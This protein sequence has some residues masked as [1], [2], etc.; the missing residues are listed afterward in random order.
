M[1]TTQKTVVLDCETDAL[2]FTKCHVVVCRDVETDEVATFRHIH[3]YP[4][5]LQEYLNEVS[6]IIGHNIIGF[7]YAVLDKYVGRSFIHNKQWVDTLIVS[8]ILNYNI[9]GGHSLEAWGARLGASKDTFNDF[10][11]WSVELEKRCIQD[12]LLTKVLYNTFS[13]YLG[14]PKWKKPID[15]EH[16][17]VFLCNTLKTNGF[18]FNYPLAINLQREL[19][20]KVE[21]LRDTFSMDF[22]AK[23]VLFKSFVPSLTKAGTIAA[24]DFRWLEE[25]RVLP[26]Y[27]EGSEFSL[28]SSVPFNPSS[29]KQCVE[30]LN[31]AGWK[32]TSK[33]KGHL[34]AERSGNTSALEDYA[35]YG[36][37]IDEENLATLSPE[38]PESARKLA[39]YLLLNSRLGDLDEWL[40]LYSPSTGRIHGT[41]NGIGSWTHRKSHSKPNMANIPALVNRKGLPQPYGPEFRSLWQAEEGK[42]LVGCDAEGIQLRVFAHL[43]NDKKLIEA[44]ANGKKDDKTDVH[45]LNMALLDPI[46]NTREV[47]KT[48]IY[49]LF[50]GAKTRKQAEILSCTPKQAKEGLSKIMAFYPGWRKL[51]EGQLKQEGARGY[52]EG[53]DG[54]LV[55]TPG[56]HYVLAGHLQNGESVIMKMASVLWNEE[57]QKRGIPY[58]FVNDV[59]DEWQTETLPEHAEEIGQLQADSIRVVGEML[60]LHCPLAGKYVIG[61]SWKETH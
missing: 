36:W 45:H 15:L 47:A 34:L 6:T 9:E 20:A 10:S 29:P 32:P 24:K 1:Q 2:K 37:K 60:G 12:T 38:A 42:V 48:Y 26:P 27:Y 31:A 50:L 11:K 21:D 13:K 7:D 41:F 52:F 35:V 53:L 40:A 58:K 39:E 57:L 44:V 17:V 51:Q 14:N 3:L 28:Y 16:K 25:P 4:E 56:E 61:K 46:C 54:R 5:K 55:R 49:A 33:T 22:P 43:C 19:L 30:R 59:H 18:S 8:R 23:D